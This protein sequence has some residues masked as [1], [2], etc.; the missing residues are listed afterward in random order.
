MTV[1]HQG[2]TVV[3][4][5]ADAAAEWMRD[6]GHRVSAARRLVL[7]ALFAAPGPISAEQIADGLDGRLPV[8]DLTSVYRNLETLERLGL[9]RH[10][11]A[12]HGAGMYALAREQEYVACSSCGEVRAL[13]AES[14][15]EVR[16]VIRRELGIAARFD[17]FP[18]VGLCAGC[19]KASPTRVL[20]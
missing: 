3:A 6:H 20:Q 9:V 15:D 17:H 1:A 12:G 2:P 5:D 10:F 18:I 11:H 8:S 4:S 16:K 7:E 13:E 19:A 14:F